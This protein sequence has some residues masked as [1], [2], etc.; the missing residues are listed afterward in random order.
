MKKRIMNM[1]LSVILVSMVGCNA[2]EAS[3]SNVASNNMMNDHVGIG[4]MQMAKDSVQ[5]QHS[6][7]KEDFDRLTSIIENRNGRIIIEMVDATVLDDDGNGSDSFGFYV[8]YDSGQFS[9][10]DKVRSIFVYNPKTNYLDD[11]VCRVDQLIE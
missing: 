1:V 9:K 11:I 3:T 5:V 2:S 10:G 7:T 8:K 4:V 6:K